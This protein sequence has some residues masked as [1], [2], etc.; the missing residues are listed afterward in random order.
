MRPCFNFPYPAGLLII[1]CFIIGCRDGSDAKSSQPSAETADANDEDRD[2]LAALAK[3]G[4]A[5]QKFHEA[6]GSMPSAAIFSDNGRPVLSWR[7]ALLPFLD[8]QDLYGQF[9]LD[10]PWDS[11][12]NQQLL[13][14]MPAV[15]APKRGPAPARP[16]ST[17]YQVFTGPDAPFRSDAGMVLHKTG[18]SKGTL[19]PRITDFRDGASQTFLLVES[20]QP[21]EWTRP[22]DLIY[23]AGAPLPALGFGGRFYLALADG[24]PHF[25][26]LST[27]ESV[28]RGGITP[29]GQIIDSRLEG[30]VTEPVLYSDRRSVLDQE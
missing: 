11:E 24:S 15:F 9:R 30:K 18:K 14:K 7:V 23:E 29:R 17:Y 12:H 8:E 3:I 20:S 16:F 22:A 28:I 13:A 19:G 5:F 26:S 1:G 2:V 10:E 6:H 25:L 4:A 27:D 21:V